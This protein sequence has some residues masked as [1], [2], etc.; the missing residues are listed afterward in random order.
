MARPKTITNEA[1]LEAARKVFLKRGYQAGTAE[2]ARAAGV[3]EGSIFKHF[4]SKND[5]F[6]EAM[7]AET[8]VQECERELID[9]VGRGEVRE[10]LARVGK[11]LLEHFLVVMPRAITLHSSGVSMP[12]CDGDGG[13]PPPLE[14]V[15]VLARY[16]R[17]EIRLGRLKLDEPEILAHAVVAG[18]MHYVMCDI[19]YQYRAGDPAVYVR[20]LVDA[21]LHGAMSPASRPVWKGRKS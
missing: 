3:S 9:S 10:T 14:H 18:L 15:D 19:L 21:L 2:V 16:F 11:K 8:R 12:R 7:R 1:I 4:R 5:L 17:A 6:C 13:R 20:T